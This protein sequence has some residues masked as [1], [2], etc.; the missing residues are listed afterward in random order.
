MKLADGKLLRDGDRVRHHDE[1]SGHDP[2]E[3]TVKNRV[4]YSRTYK[5]PA[6][7]DICWDAESEPDDNVILSPSDTGSVFLLGNLT[8]I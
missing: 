3:G 7:F 6:R 4:G 5:T 8:K 1:G 2:I